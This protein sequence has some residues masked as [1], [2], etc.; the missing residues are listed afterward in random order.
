[1]EN[2]QKQDGFVILLLTGQALV[3]GVPGLLLFGLF[4]PRHFCQKQGHPAPVGDPG[5]DQAAADKSAE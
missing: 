5:K 1:M 4:I 3:S 2:S